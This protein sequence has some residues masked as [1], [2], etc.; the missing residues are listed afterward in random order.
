MKITCDTNAM[1][2]TTLSTTFDCRDTYLA[3]SDK[4]PATSAWAL[5]NVA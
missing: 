2:S 5:E 4:I 3:H 1:L